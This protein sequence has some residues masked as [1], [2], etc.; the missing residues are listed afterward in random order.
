MAT[1][2]DLTA[3]SKAVQAFETTWIPIFWYTKEVI[4]ESAFVYGEFRV[5][6]NTLRI[7]FD[8]VPSGRHRKN[9]IESKHSVIPSIYL[10]P[11]TANNNKDHILNAMKALNISNEISG[12]ITASAYEVAR[13]YT[14]PIHRELVRR[15]DGV[16]EEN[17]KMKFRKELASSTGKQKRRSSSVRVSLL[18]RAVVG[19]TNST[20][21]VPKNLP[22]SA[23][24]SA[25]KYVIPALL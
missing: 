16:I 1:V 23:I 15:L 22:I 8:L 9:T 12:T 20:F 10:R 25:K 5:Y 17:L 7:T 4:R 3:L 18:A 13:R 6:L 11:M 19:M 2:V 24:F 14:K 21:A